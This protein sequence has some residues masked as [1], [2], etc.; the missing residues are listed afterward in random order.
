MDNNIGIIGIGYLPRYMSVFLESQID[1][2]RTITHRFIQKG[3]WETALSLFGCYEKTA[4]S[5]GSWETDT[6][7]V[8]LAENN[9]SVR[10]KSIMEEYT[11]HPSCA[12]E[13]SYHQVSKKE[14]DSFREALDRIIAQADLLHDP[15]KEVLQAFEDAD[16]ELP[17]NCIYR[18]LKN[19]FIRPSLEETP[20]NRGI[21]LSN[22]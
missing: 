18:F 15:S 10:Y 8:A 17:D 14:L 22:T 21:E 5:W 16:I 13:L 3:C 2:N 1:G 20:L 12:G 11:E 19:L 9:L 7:N 6:W 4:Q